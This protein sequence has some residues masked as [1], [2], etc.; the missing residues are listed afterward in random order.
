MR[1]MAMRAGSVEA[2]LDA[3]TSFEAPPVPRWLGEDET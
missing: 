1:A 3:L 2:A